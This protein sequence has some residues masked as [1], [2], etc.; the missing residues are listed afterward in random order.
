MSKVDFLAPLHDLHFCVTRVAGVND[1]LD[2]ADR[3][4]S[5][6][7]TLE[8]PKTRTSL[9]GPD[10]HQAIIPEHSSPAQSPT[11]RPVTE[12]G[13][14]G[15]AKG[16]QQQQQLLKKQQQQSPQREKSDLD[17]KRRNK[18]KNCTREARDFA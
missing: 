7:A 10:K 13:S 18:G 2:R 16:A 1:P 11:P 4:I 17:V 14:S 12:G 8:T 6:H 9:F 3:K 5:A 15:S